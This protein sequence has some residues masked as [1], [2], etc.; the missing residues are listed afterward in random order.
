MAQLGTP[1]IGDPRY[2]NIEN[3]MP[4]PGLGEGLHLH[5]RRIVLPLR[6]GKK[7]DISAP[8]PLHMRESF[9]ALGFDPDRYDAQNTDPE[10]AA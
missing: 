7:V 10:T 2:F 3:W 6:N 8:L 4:A 1:I 9:E 5:A